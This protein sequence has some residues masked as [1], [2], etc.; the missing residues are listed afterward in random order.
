M[1]TQSIH[2]DVRGQSDH[3][4]RPRS[5]P[6]SRPLETCAVSTECQ[7]LPALEI[8]I[9]LIEIR[10]QEHCARLNLEVLFADGE[11]GCL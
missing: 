10:Y 3:A 6:V 9:E 11:M 7:D 8:A 5:T 2:E 1:S 4:L